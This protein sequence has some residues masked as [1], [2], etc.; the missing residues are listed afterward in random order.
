MMFNAM[1]VVLGALLPSSSALLPPPSP[2]PP[3]PP[4][5]MPP[6]WPGWGVQ[7][8]SIVRTILPARASGSSA[9]SGP[10]RCP[11]GQLGCVVNPIV[12]PAKALQTGGSHRGT[13]QAPAVATGGK[14]VSTATSPGCVRHSLA[15]RLPNPTGT[16]EVANNVVFTQVAASNPSNQ[17]VAS[18]N[19]LGWPGM[20]QKI[21][22]AWG[23]ADGNGYLDVAVI[24]SSGK[25]RFASPQ[26]PSLSPACS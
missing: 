11:S 15:S 6:L 26:T 8:A 19:Q 12:Q 18:T 23:D 22:T 21:L 13:F 20:G 1:F 17:L 4:P 3:S 5:P 9:A 16:S 7:G 24:T 25:G 10:S 2:P 14:C